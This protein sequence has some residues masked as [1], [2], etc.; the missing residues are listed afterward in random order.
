MPDRCLRGPLVSVMI[1]TY[2]QETWIEDAI[3][4]ALAQ[5]Y[6]NL[7]VVVCDDGSPDATYDR[8]R[9]VNDPRLRVHSN[10][11]N[12]GRVGNYRRLL[13]DLA[14]GEWALM[15]DGDDRLTDTGF[16][17]RAMEAAL[18]DP[19]VVLVGGGHGVEAAGTVRMHLPT[20]R[21]RIIPGRDAFFAWERLGIAHLAALYRRDLA[22]RLDF[23][24]TDRLTADCE[25]LLGLVVHGKVALL[26]RE[27]GVWRDHGGN[28][29]RGLD[30]EAFRDSLGCFDGPGEAAVALG[31]ARGRV[32]RWKRRHV[33]GQVMTFFLQ[34]LRSLGTEE[35][36]VSKTAARNLARLAE[37]YPPL[38]YPGT[39][40]QAGGLAYAL[41]G[42]RPL[43]AA[44]LGLRGALR[45]FRPQFRG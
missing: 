40:W 38:R 12:L 34:N 30:Y 15:L 14:Q 9:A 24:K 19:E 43:H 3:H 33:A 28:A 23:Y 17:R 16:V 7:E 36:L 26:A 31:L 2:G 37:D 11:V 6:P 10:A 8:A 25:S 1:P 35:L 21:D 39:F 13:F 27:V 32:S 44:Y 4:G 20:T 29:S 45:K 18:A 41:L 42:A 5:D 22:V